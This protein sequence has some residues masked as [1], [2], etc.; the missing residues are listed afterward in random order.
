MQENKKDKNNNCYF[1]KDYDFI[2]SRQTNSE[3][4]VAIIEQ[5]NK[6]GRVIHYTGLNFKFCPVC[7]KKL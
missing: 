2:K 3:C 1:C 6:K 5:F 4:T 7:G